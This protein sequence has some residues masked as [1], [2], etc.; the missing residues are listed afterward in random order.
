MTLHIPPTGCMC[1]SPHLL[2]VN[3]RLVPDQLVDQPGPS[4]IPPLVQPSLDRRADVHLGQVAQGGNGGQRGRGSEE[5]AQ[6]S[7]VACGAGAQVVQL[8]K[9]SW[10]GNFLLD[11]LGRVKT[12]SRVRNM[13]EEKGA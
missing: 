13:G 4:G 9:S 1:E 11:R 2:A 5:D 10:D 7:E 6:Q 8:H 12:E 3:I